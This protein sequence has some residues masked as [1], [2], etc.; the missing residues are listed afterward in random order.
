[1]K[2]DGLQYRMKNRRV[3]LCQG[4][5]GSWLIRCKRL[6]DRRREIIQTRLR[7]SDEAMQAIIGMYMQIRGVLV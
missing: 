1:M 4:P 6:G 5:D 3:F 7:V 2:V